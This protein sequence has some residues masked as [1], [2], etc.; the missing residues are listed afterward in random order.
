MRRV[1]LVV[2]GL[3]E[4][5]G[6]PVVARFLAQ[7]MLDSGRYQPEFVSV[8]LSA[9]DAT[10]VRLRSP[11][12]WWSGVGTRC[13]E[14]EGWPFVHVG[15]VATELEFQRYRPLHHLLAGEARAAPEIAPG[16]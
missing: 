11:T 15:C 16:E 6:V 13:G 10:S 5:G 12:T 14:W 4:G 2:P 9:G 7:V 8:P 1:A 3:E